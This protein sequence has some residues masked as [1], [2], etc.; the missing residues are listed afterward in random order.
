[1]F[2]N[3]KFFLLEAE[4]SSEAKLETNA[5]LILSQH[6]YYGLHYQVSFFMFLFSIYTSRENPTGPLGG[7]LR[8]D[9]EF[10]QQAVYY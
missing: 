2:S 7:F 5:C 9:V 6:V 3:R 10:Y 1:M 4:T 8:P